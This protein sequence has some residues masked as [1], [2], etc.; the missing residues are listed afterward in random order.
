[1]ADKKLESLAFRLTDLNSLRNLFAHLNYDFA[2]D[3][4]NKDN[5]NDD[6]KSIITE[7]RMIAKKDDYRIYYLQT[8]TDSL[9]YWKGISTKIIKENHGLCL[10]CSHNPT[11][12]KWVFSNLSKEFSKSFS[13]TRH[14][15]IDI[16]PET[17]VP[18][19]F[20]D[21][22][23]K[24]SISKEDSTTAILAKMS[25][26]FDSFAIGIHDELTVNVF[27]ALKI[28]SEGIIF[29]KTNNL[30]LSNETLDDIREDIFILL[31]R[32]IFILYA[33]DR[34]IFPTDHPVYKKEFSL[35]WI[36]EEWLLKSVNI[37]KLDEYE[38]QKRIKKLFRLIEVGS[39]ELDY[40]KEDFFMRSYYGRIFD[41][42]LNPKL[43]QWSIPNSNFLGMLSLLTRNRDK[44]GNYFI[45]DY[46]A[47]ETRHLGSIYESL[48]EYHLTVEKN[49][50]VEL[51]NPED[52]KSSASYYTPEPIVDYM[53]QNTIEPLIKKI[54]SETEDKFEQIEKI[55]SL[56][57]LDPA[58]GSGHFLIGVI[59]YTASRI[60][61]IEH[62][63]ISE[64][65]L[66]ERKREVA[67]RCVYGVDFNPLAVDLAMVSIWLETLS[68]DKPLSFL[69]AHLKNGN[70]LIGTQIDVLFNKQTTLMESQKGREQFKRNI[71]DFIMFENLEEDNASAVKTKL[72][73]YQ[74]IQSF[75]SIY[76]NIKSLLNCKVAES[77]GFD[78]PVVSDFKAKIAEN[79]LDFFSDDKWKKIQNLS[80][81]TKFFHWDLE[82]PDIFYDENADKKNDSGFD[83]VV[84]N[85][86]Y[87]SWNK[88]S[89]IERKFFEDGTYLDCRYSCRINHADAHPNYYLFFIVGII[90]LIK[91]NG[92]SSIIIPQEWLEYNRCK[93][94]RNYIL[95]K[96]TSVEI[97]QFHPN[98]KVFVGHDTIGTNSLILTLSKQSDFKIH[99]YFINELDDSK[100]KNILSKKHFSN[101]VIKDFSKIGDSP[102][103]FISD[104]N[105]T[106]KTKIESMNNLFYFNDEKYF[107][108]NGGFQP[109]VN[110]ASLFEINSNE[111]LKIPQNEMEILY[112]LILDSNEITPY[113]VSQKNQKYWIVANNI[114]LESDFKNKFP[115]IYHILSNRIKDKKKNWWH[116]P[117]V[118]N[119][120]LIQENGY[121]ILSPRT[122]KEPSFA[123]DDKKSVFKGTNTMIISKKL[124]PLYVLGIINSKLF[125]WWYSNFGAEYHGGVTKKYEPDK[126]KNFS[127]P[128]VFSEDKK[129]DIISMTSKIIENKK[130]LMINHNLKKDEICNIELSIEKIKQKLNTV[131]FEI[132][133][134]TQEEIK[135]IVRD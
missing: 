126:V 18:K 101:F 94:F 26:A 90:N 67:R 106:I 44:K 113:V 24:I 80:S 102:W 8:N 120:K 10:I 43:E 108:V 37:E 124:D 54:Q 74:K 2:D 132:Y 114:S 129:N 5:W 79:S 134:I 87:I 69:S 39:E 9:K 72:E 63:Q 95:N 55:L 121:K 59:N 73:K 57:I 29:D 64:Q 97:I 133:K 51:P 91:E 111:Y 107:S 47:L 32:I 68:S 45:L 100:V 71:K 62:G 86:P 92:I 109:P 66:I 98:Y 81:D 41:R 23:E 105:Y 11:G 83:A 61:E 85:P 82:F 93:E 135:T 35:K 122:A 115:N 50:I 104:L 22:L 65:Q 19:T 17:G 75:G 123:F 116:F 49:K 14:I 96:S 31:Y 117:N 112:N 78:I 118:R 30:L 21:F 48:L 127:M 7:A 70:S 28:I 20:L 36:K 33:E 12:F 53:V 84:G 76:Y 13:E 125:D 99:H 52:R 77:F 130:L 60:C 110:I 56:N 88:I 27:E 89:S 40:N 58:M 38:V 16:R 3:P 46:S 42:K 1:M 34:G 4:V 15:P 25:D 131:I 119:L 6:E 103:K 128:I